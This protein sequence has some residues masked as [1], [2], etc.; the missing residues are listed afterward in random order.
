MAENK[1]KSYK[2]MPY[3]IKESE[4]SFE[5]MRSAGPGGQNVNKVST[6][7]RLR[8]DI[9]RSSSIPEQIKIRLEQLAGSKADKNGVLII[10][11]QRFRTQQANRRDALKRLEQMIREAAKIPRK[12]KVTR[13]ALSVTLGR[14]EQKR[15]RGE[16]K[17]SRQRIRYDGDM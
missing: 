14:L 17:T 10:R 9:R 8:F 4:L 5:F 3:R 12:R 15:L 7:V 13:P 2:R 6:A 16:K 11:A 1:G